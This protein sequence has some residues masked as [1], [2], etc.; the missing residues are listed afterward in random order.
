MPRLT[1]HQLQAK[2]AEG[3]KIVVLTLYD[4]N[5]AKLAGKAGVDILFVGDSLGMVI[6]GEENTLSVTVSEIAYHTTCVTR[7]NT[8]SVIMADLPFMSYYTPEIAAN[9]AKQ[10]MQA[11]AEIIKVEGGA[12]LA[13]TIDYLSTR[14][15][16]ICAHIGLTP[17]YIHLIGGYKIQGRSKEQATE[18]MDAAILL[19]KAGAKMIVLECVPQALAKEITESLHI[20]VIGIG[21]GPHCDGQV[22]VLYDLLGMNSDKPMKFTKNYLQNNPGGIEAAIA[23]Y[24]REVRQGLFPTL[25]HT[26]T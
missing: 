2:K 3:G 12:W 11:G 23:D 8:N 14:G 10:L 15:V 4:S 16:P 24:A 18:L 26:F 9:H 6:K 7:G 17:Q 13:D 19:E 20:P 5:F 21:A 22:L 25:E 1:M